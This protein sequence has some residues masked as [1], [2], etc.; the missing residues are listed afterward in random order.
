MLAYLWTNMMSS[1][2]NGSS[3]GSALSLGCSGVIHIW[4]KLSIHAPPSG[5]I[6]EARPL[7]S[8]PVI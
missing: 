5:N 2:L 4:L 7:P 6:R 8:A 1:P 3:F